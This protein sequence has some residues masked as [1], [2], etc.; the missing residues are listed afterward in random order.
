VID[1][2][3]NPPTADDMVN[4]QDFLQSCCDLFKESRKKRVQLVYF[5][6]A[7]PKDLTKRY[8]SLVPDIRAELS[9]AAPLPSGETRHRIDRHKISAGLAYT[10][11]CSQPMR[12]MRQL[13][14]SPT[15][16]PEDK[17]T[18][19]NALFALFVGITFLEKWN[20]GSGR[21]I[22]VSPK[23]TRFIAEHH[24][25]MLRCVDYPLMFSAQTFYLIE[26][27]CLMEAEQDKYFC[28]HL[29]CD[30][31]TANLTQ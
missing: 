12:D 29:L 6:P 30:A 8:Y 16:E 11:L 28:G 27:L 1:D 23:V 15:R 13:Q 21:R 20:A 3:P 19:L 9:A 14:A 22:V 18:W 26:Q 25:W 4:R 2:E 10:I 17:E 7:V 24:K 31:R 5:D